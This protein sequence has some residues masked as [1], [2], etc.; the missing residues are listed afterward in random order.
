MA[1]WWQSAVIYQ[2]YPRSFQD[3]DGDGIGDLPGIAA[4]LDH[5][6]AL[7][8]D[9]VW[10]SP[11]YP[12]PMADFGYDVADHR[13]VD[14]A[15][16]TLAD[17]DRLVA[18]AH[19]RGLRVILDYVPN[20]TA[21]THPW[22]L[23]SRASHENPKRDWYI[24][25]E[26]APDGGPPNNWRSEFGGAAW[27]LDAATGQYFY[28]A[29]LPQQ[30]DLNW[31]NPAVQDAMLDVLRFWLD[32]G[33]DG[34]RVDAIHHLFEDASLRDNPPNPAWRDGMSP[35]RRVLRTHTMDQPEVQGAVAAMRRLADLYPGERLLIGE[36]YLPIDRL[37]AY[38]GVD[39]SGFHLPFNFHLLSTPWSAPAIADL[40]ARY[41]AAL[42]EG[43]W[44]NWVL[45]NHDRSRVASRLG[46]RQARIAAMLL[47]TLRGT[48][49][50][51]QGEELGLTDVP[52]PPGLVQDP[53]EK[54]VPGLGLGRDPVRT[55][56]PWDGTA[57]AGFT[58][59][60]PWLPLG[61]AHRPLHATAQARDPGSM[62]RL[63]RDL[64]MLR[65]REPALSLG[66]IA[67]V[68][69]EGDLLRYERRDPDGGR[70]LLVLLNLAEA[71]RTLRVGGTP[72]L[73]TH[74]DA[75]SGTRLRSLEGMVM[76]PE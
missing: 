16:G 22:F 18:A 68:A 10:I 43:A 13:G 44:P 45:G 47:L 38:Y 65:R 14:P 27:T 35:A 71:E 15:F 12:S 33:V 30:P 63:Y 53:W 56:M 50:L 70:G 21:D 60:T 1:R 42:P 76:R 39:L 8:V 58:T 51:Y 2:V 11:F 48:P 41:E 54:R 17:F 74:G 67:A 46:P 24:W 25:R 55:P 20:H 23:D 59:G 31:R 64:L 4:R 7:G 26:P 37:M 52:I 61:E 72:L 3:S 32:R 75:G 19:E 40:I 9:A 6:V 57:Q 49:T 66:P 69:A 36:A 73:S 29:Y 5:L 28:H 34:F 62:L